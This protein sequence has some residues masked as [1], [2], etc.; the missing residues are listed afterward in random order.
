[1]MND[2]YDDSPEF[3]ASSSH[4]TKDN[5]TLKLQQNFMFFSLDCRKIKT[6]TTTH[7]ASGNPAVTKEK[8]SQTEKESNWKTKHT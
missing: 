7:N 4:V 6:W 5:E 1:M 2:Y 3:N 8:Q